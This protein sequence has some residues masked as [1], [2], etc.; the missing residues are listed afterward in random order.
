MVV[1]EQL[2]VTVILTLAF[3]D[4]PEATVVPRTATD[5]DQGASAPVGVT[6]TR[7]RALLV[8]AS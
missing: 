5:Q 8:A 1:I 4:E 3:D 6:V 2:F 7:T